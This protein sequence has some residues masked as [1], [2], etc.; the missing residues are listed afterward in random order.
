MKERDKAIFRLLNIQGLGPVRI[1]EIIQAFDPLEK[2]FQISEKEIKTKIVLPDKIISN[3]KNSYIVQEKLEKQYEIIEKYKIHYVTIFDEFY[4]IYLKE[5]YSPPPAL[6]YRGDVSI[7]SN[8]KIIGVVGTRRADHYGLDVTTSIC[9]ELAGIGNTVIV[10]GLAEGI[11]TAAHKAALN[12]GGLTAAVVGTSLDICYP[13]RNKNLME[14]IIKKGV[15]ISE[16]LPGTKIEPSNFPKRNRI[17][18][19]LSKGI[20]VTQAGIKSGA[21]ITAGYAIEQNRDVFAVPGAVNQSRSEGTNRLLKNSA[22][23]VTNAQDIMEQFPDWYCNLPKLQKKKIFLNGDELQ[24]VRLLESGPLR[25]AELSKLLDNKLSNSIFSILLDLELK[26][27]IT[28]HPGTGYGLSV[29]DYT[30][31]SM[32]K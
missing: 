10:S 13:A 31:E 14:E 22:V 4:P 2:I 29:T 17:I 16:F 30:I 3:I 23:L 7:L 26:K 24:V 9:S 21:L 27:V 12:S 28:N 18:S 25:L 5:I 19:G 1:N 6:F 20:L 8:K 32:E 11:D 15:I